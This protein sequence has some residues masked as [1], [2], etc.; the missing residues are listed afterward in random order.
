MRQICTYKMH[1][2]EIRIDSER[3]KYGTKLCLLCGREIFLGPKRC[4]HGSLINERGQSLCELCRAPHSDAV[5]HSSPEHLEAYLDP[6][7]SELTA[8]EPQTAEPVIEFDR[9]NFEQEEEPY[10]VVNEE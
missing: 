6:P 4:R 5:H 1:A 3:G 10:S 8:Q 7:I 2:E 9:E